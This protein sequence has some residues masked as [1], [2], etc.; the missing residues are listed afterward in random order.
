MRI[1]EPFYEIWKYDKETMKFLE[2]VGRICYK[3]EDRIKSGTADPFIQGLVKNGHE[4]MIEHSMISVKFIHN[5]GFSHEL[6]RHRLASYAQESTRYCNYSKDKSDN[7]IT[8]IKPY[9][10]NDTDIKNIKGVR[11]YWK[12]S[13][14]FDEEAYLY[15]VK[16]G[17]KPQGARGKLPIDLKT[18]I[19]MSANPRE[20]RSVFMLRADRP[21]HP[22]MRRLMIPLLV[23]MATMFPILFGDIKEYI[24]ER[25]KKPSS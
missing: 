21:A 11:E 12:K 9:W 17:L 25:M 20:W 18:E 23:T 16:N 24:I 5:R 22:D 4:A 2:Q 1:V 15:M 8:V 14:E 13:T 6:V 7:Q 3:S 10:W 19:V